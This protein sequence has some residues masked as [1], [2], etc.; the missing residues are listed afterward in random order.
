[1]ASRT[2]LDPTQPGVLPLAGTAQFSEAGIVSRTL[3]DQDGVRVTLF[4]FAAGQQLT[5]HASPARALIQ[6][7]SGSCEFVVAGAERP[8][9]TGDLLHLPPGTPHAVRAAEPF[10]MLLT[11]IRRP[12]EPAR[13]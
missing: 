12:A 4:A 7:L 6:V 2:L 13:A 10:S 3:L 5:E 11:L 9:R 8:L 1:M